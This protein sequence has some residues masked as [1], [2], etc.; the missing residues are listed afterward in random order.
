MNELIVYPLILLIILGAFCQLFYATQTEVEID[1]SYE[2]TLE[3]IQASGN[4]TLGETEQELQQ[5]STD[6]VFDINMTTGIIALIIGLVVVGVLAGIRVLGSGLS[7]FS[8]KLIYN[9]TVYYGLWGIFSALSFPVF[10][11][12]PT[13]GL[14][15]WLSLTLLYSLG[16]FQTTHGAS[17]GSA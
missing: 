17:G 12:I 2:G 10:L 8:V 7:E 4:Q 1:Y 9:S 14:L 3:D 11:T 5:E 6:A 16:F 13:F 15:L